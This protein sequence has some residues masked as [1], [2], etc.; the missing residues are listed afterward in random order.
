MILRTTVAHNEMKAH[1]IQIKEHQV[2][3]LMNIMA[4]QLDWVSE[5]Y[6]NCYMLLN[7]QDLEDQISHLT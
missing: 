3:G 1:A 4:A 5:A 7:S 2:L 6:H